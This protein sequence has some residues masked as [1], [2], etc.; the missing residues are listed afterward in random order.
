MKN[1]KILMIVI[2]IIAVLA[3]A[4]TVFGYLYVATDTFKSDQELFLK[5]MSQNIEKL[6]QISTLQTSQVYSNLTNETKF[7]S[8]TKINMIHSDGG[9]VSNALNDLKA[10]ID[11]QKDKD[12]EY[13]YINGQILY[14]DEKYLELELIKQDEFYGLRFP[15]VVKQI[16]SIKDDE[17][18]GTVAKDIGIDSAQLKSIINTINGTTTIGKE[19]FPQN[20]KELLKQKC[21][22]TLTDNISK[23]TF[24]NLKK[25][26]ITYDNAT[27]N[28]NAYSVSLSSEQV[29]GILVQILNNFKDGNFV[30]GESFE[31]QIDEIIANITDE[32]IPEVKMTV[33]EQK[34]KTIRTIIES[35]I[36][37][38]ILENKEE[39]GEVKTIIQI[40]DL[41]AKNISEKIIEIS[42]KSEGKQ[43]RFEIELKAIE[44]E[45]EYTITF[46]NQLQKEETTTT[47]NSSITYKRDILEVGINLENTINSDSDFEKKQV[48]ESNNNVVLNDLNQERRTYIINL[49]KE[50]VPERVIE[51]LELLGEKLGV[52]EEENIENVE[53]E[54]PQVEINK[55]NAKFEFYTGESVSAENV[56]ALL[57]IVQDNLAEYT[58]LSREESE[59]VI[60]EDKKYIIQLKIEKDVTNEDAVS[61]ILDKISEQK[62]YKVN[63][64]Y[65][66]DNGLIEY[67][68]IEEVG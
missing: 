29:E 5:Y 16:I 44:G 65:K 52:N 41:G 1:K 30:D 20:E 28:A 2:I 18:F 26:M 37:K 53:N 10:T 64:S 40:S 58:I 54:I 47:V 4:G 50:K 57:D 56:K 25:A 15:D 67:I 62:K 9:E 45:E 12:N 6:K 68:T 24:T 66:D 21:I 23:G 33:Y 14:L 42:K 48:L 11:M 38:I 59:E 46:L 7:D 36:Y 35:G 3:V 39:N 32:E 22:Q 61:E 49:L 55:F 31:E 27:I 63:I 8:T 34:E 13:F 19:I 60:N 51:R 17:N 43:E